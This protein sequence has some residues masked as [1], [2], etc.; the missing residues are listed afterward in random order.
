[1]SGVYW[2]ALKKYQ[3]VEVAKKLD[4][5]MLILAGQRDY[6]VTSK[7]YQLWKKAL[8]AKKN[9]TIKSYRPLNHLFI[10]GKGKPN[11]GEYNKPGHV[12]K[13][14]IDDIAKWIQQ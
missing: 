3:Q 8:G 14:V 5:P 1:M 4:K 10:A 6:Q 13:E 9:V 11:P 2:L 7:D 12:A